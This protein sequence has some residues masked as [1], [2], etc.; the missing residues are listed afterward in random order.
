ME[1]VGIQGLLWCLALGNKR[2]VVWYTHSLLPTTSLFQVDV[3]LGNGLVDRVAA[4]GR[5][6][7]GGNEDCRG[8]ATFALGQ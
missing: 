2:S 7:G 8:E 6:D 1:T 4:T 3:G 5:E